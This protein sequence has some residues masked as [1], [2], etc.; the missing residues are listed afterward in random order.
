MKSLHNISQRVLLVILDGFGINQNKNNNA[1]ISSKTP[2]IDL[3]FKEYPFTTLE[4]GGTHVGLPKGIVGNSEV[5]HMNIGAGRPVRQDI[6]RINESIKNK[7]LESMSEIQTLIKQSQ[8][9]T[10]IIHLLGLL[11]D[12]GVHSHID[13]IIE[14]AKVLHSKKIKV[15]L[16]A[17]T[18]GRDTKPKSAKNIL[19]K[20]IPVNI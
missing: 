19:K 2:F 6:I 4:A 20:L 9:N 12:G 11:S 3:A 14:I 8:K 1:V 10:N 7:T 5:G 18:D 17:F 15:Y 13:H 16:H